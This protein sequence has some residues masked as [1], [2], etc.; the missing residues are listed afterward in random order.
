MLSLPSRS[1]AAWFVRGLSNVVSLPVL[2]LIAAQVGFTTLAR[3]AGFSAGEVVLM[4]LAVWALPSQVLFVGLVGS[5]ATLATVVV[6]VALASVRFLPMTMAWAPVV[7]TPA[8]PQWVLLAL[9]WFVA[10][11]A[12]VFAMA[13][14]P[15]LPREARL[16]FFAGFAMTLTASNMV[17]V[18]VAYETIG[19]LPAVAS[20]AFVFLTPIYFLYAMWGAARI[21]ADRLAMGLGLALGPVATALFPSLD[22]LLAGLVAGT[23]AYLAGRIARARA[24]R[25]EGGAP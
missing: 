17:A 12:W 7:R 8:T 9:S 2:V 15:A 21:P 13:R 10:V 19:R 25:A 14:L 16:P 20:A 23:A 5:G 24:R 11:T 18:Y 4:T 1:A 3:E 22:I 6:A